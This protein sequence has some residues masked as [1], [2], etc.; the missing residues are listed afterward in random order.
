MVNCRPLYTPNYQYLQQLAKVSLPTLIDG[1][2]GKE[3]IKVIVSF[4]TLKKITG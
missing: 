4:L 1:G 2:K 3:E